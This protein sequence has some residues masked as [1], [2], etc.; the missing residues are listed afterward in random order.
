MCWY[1]SVI[2]PLLD[3]TEHVVDGLKFITFQKGASFIE[4]V[5]AESITGFFFLPKDKERWASILFWTS[6]RKH[7]KRSFFMVANHFSNGRGLRAA[8][9]SA[10]YVIVVWVGRS[11]QDMRCHSARWSMLLS[12]LVQVWL[13]HLSHRQ[14]GWQTRGIRQRWH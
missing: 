2:T 6:C 7:I 13:F 8:R 14:C 12:C 10:A 9:P 3:D 4:Y 11:V 1:E 5:S